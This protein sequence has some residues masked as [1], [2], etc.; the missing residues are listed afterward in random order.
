MSQTGGHGTSRLGYV[1][2]LV[3]NLFRFDPAV[4]LVTP[5]DEVDRIVKHAFWNRVLWA[6]LHPLNH[7]LGKSSTP[8]VTIGT[9]RS[10]CSPVL[11][12]QQQVEP[13]RLIILLRHEHPHPV[14]PEL[15]M[16]SS[17]LDISHSIHRQPGPALLQKNGSDL[18]PRGIGIV[19]VFFRSGEV[20]F[21]EIVDY[22]CCRED[23]E[24]TKS[25][26]L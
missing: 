14:A 16:H 17:V 18:D 2:R 20:D 13:V 25:S 8:I 23:V 7:P 21:T 10:P 4:V 6:V 24:R 22:A 11:M 9:K 19:G 15:V 5:E 3:G 26:F 12:H 1:V